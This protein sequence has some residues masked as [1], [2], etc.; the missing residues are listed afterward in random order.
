MKQFVK[1]FFALLL[2]TSLFGFYYYNNINPGSTPVTGINYNQ[3][4]NHN[5]AQ[6]DAI[7]S[8][9]TV[10]PMPGPGGFGSGQSGVSYTRNDTGWVYFIGDASVQNSATVYRYNVNTN[11]WATMS[12][13]PQGRDRLSC[14]VLRDSIYAI[15]GA[16]TSATYSNTL[17][18][19]SVNNNAWTTRAPLPVSAIGWTGSVGYQDSLIYVAGGNDGALAVSTVFLYNA[20]S[21]TWR[22]ATSLPVQVFG[23]GF[24]RSGDTL[25]YAGGIDNA[26]TVLNT[27][28][29]GVISS[30]D[31]SIITWT[32]GMTM[33]A[34]MFRTSAASWGNKGIILT[35]GSTSTTF[36]GL[37]TT[38]VYSPGANMWTP[39]PNK[40]TAT[41]YSTVGSVILGGGI[42]KFVCY[43]GW[44]GAGYSTATHVFTDT[45]VLTGITTINNQ[46]P[47]K[48]VVSQNYPN[49]FNPSTNIKFS[50]P[51]SGIVKLKVFDILGREVA[52]LV[53]E[54][55]PAGNY[56]VDFNASNLTS[57]IYLYK[58][59]SG[60]FTE[61]KKM[62][63]VK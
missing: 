39:Q 23:G 44:D 48:Y 10:A 9:S 57:G 40:P 53:N 43:G 7:G 37:N 32:T 45:L 11:T 15:A 3:E 22:P 59:Q 58:I 56:A 54:F 19:Y 6:I 33:P 34:A 20:I 25:V 8:W 61:T 41:T 28:Y 2:I 26:S 14:A 27:T 38:L 5:E 16:N 31:R 42:M 4:T 18:L 17:Y 30:S 36:T 60:E 63:L 55:K 35:N 24:A 50:I 13:L 52:S 21:N 62:I 47:S 49:P 51:V 46:I 12:P 1:I 29:R